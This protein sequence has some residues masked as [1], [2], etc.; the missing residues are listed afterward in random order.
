MRRERIIRLSALSYDAKRLEAACER[1][2]LTLLV[3]YGSRAGASPEQ[4]PDRVAEPACP[5][6]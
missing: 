6:A 3:A 4:R 5:T 1:L 2:G